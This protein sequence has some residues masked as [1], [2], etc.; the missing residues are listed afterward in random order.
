M[1][2]V[3]KLTFQS[4]IRIAGVNPYVQVSAARAAALR[5]GWRRPLPVLVRLN[6]RP[7]MS[8][9]INLMPIGDGS[10]YLYLHGDL[11]RA[12][13]T[14][15]GDRVEVELAFDA[16]YRGGPMQR[17]PEWF[18][19]PLAAN[20]KATAGWNTLTPS[21]KKEIVRYLARLKSP[22]ARARNVGRALAAL[23]G[24]PSRFMARSWGTRE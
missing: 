6:R 20:K 15:V 11:R 19:K 23:S 9:R 4:R 16:A 12:S 10:F 21:R 3:A 1:K 13:N 24:T 5:A 7:R 18:R 17:M 14:K 2:Y 22:D 8:W